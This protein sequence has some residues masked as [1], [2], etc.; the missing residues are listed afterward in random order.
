MPKNNLNPLIYNKKL[1]GRISRMVHAHTI[2]VMVECANH[3]SGCKNEAAVKSAN[4]VVEY[5]YQQ[6]K[7]QEDK[8]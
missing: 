7:R 6:L 5:F 1:Y 4:R 2:F 3:G 8:P